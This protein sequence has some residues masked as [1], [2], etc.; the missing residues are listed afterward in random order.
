MMV[1]IL[2]TDKEMAGALPV[3]AESAYLRCKSSRYGWFRSGGLVL[4][5][6]VERR[7]LFNRMVFTHQTISLRGAHTQAEEYEFLNQVV[8][9]ARGMDVDFIYQPQAT[10]VFSLVPKGAVAAPFGTYIVNLEQPVEKLWANLH[11][12][13]RNIIKKAQ[14]A[15]VEISE[16]AH[17]LDIC[18]ELIHS[19]MKRNQKL[20]V[21]LGE[22]GRFRG[23][24]AGNASFYV[25][26]KDNVAQGA[27]VIVWNAGHTAY[28]LHGGT[29]DSPFG[30]AMNLLH[31]KAM[32]DMK[33]RGV[34]QYDFVGARV[35]PPPGS[36]LETIQR[37]KA[38]FGA[39]MK[40]GYL[41]K[42]PLKP[43]LYSAYCLLARANSLVNG[44]TYKGDII[45]EERALV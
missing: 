38:R 6:I 44:A 27:A 22:L 18:H 15:G 3:V 34:K 29:S 43:L 36:K 13:H 37:F 8:A 9:A 25:A 24:L 5:F 45:D 2:T 30:G 40:Q 32:T 10:A 39:T 23:N 41:W 35:S 31:W 11:G 21:S 26:K 12:K 19:T 1:E 28:Y 42:Y 7:A 4:P 17:N 33:A 14:D 20:S 16:G